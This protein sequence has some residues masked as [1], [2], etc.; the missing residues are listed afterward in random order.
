VQIIFR[1]EAARELGQAQFW[2]E[3]KAVGLGFEFARAVEA[4]VESAKRNP[5]GHPTIEA[6]FRRVLLRK[7]PYML[8]YL[9][10]DETLLVVAVF[11][12][13][14][15]PNIWLAKPSN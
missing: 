9:P 14:R 3:S 12:T 4:A 1:P 2:Y 6:D 15:E 13:R 8:I 7:F 11:N 5:F 10:S